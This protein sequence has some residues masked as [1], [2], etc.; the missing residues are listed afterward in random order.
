MSIE[1][2]SVLLIEAFL[3]NCFKLEAAHHRVE[4]DFKEH[5]MV[6]VSF[7]HN[8]NPLYAYSV[9]GAVIFGL[10]LRKLGDFL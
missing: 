2:V 7:F 6:A 4:K 1:R 3:T 10:E 5:E 9:L 8:L